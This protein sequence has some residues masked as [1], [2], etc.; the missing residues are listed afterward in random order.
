[1]LVKFK[2][3]TLAIEIPFAET[4]LRGVAAIVAFVQTNGLQVDNGPLLEYKS[5]LIAAD[6]AGGETGE[7]QAWV[8]IVVGAP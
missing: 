2:H 7:G 5:H 3:E 8:R 4:N 1:M 6:Q